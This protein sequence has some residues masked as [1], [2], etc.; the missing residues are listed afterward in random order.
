MPGAESDDFE[1]LEVFNPDPANTIGL[2][3]LT[4]GGGI[5]F[6]VPDGV[7]LKPGERAV[8]VEN[9]S[10]FRFRYGQLVPRP[11]V[12]GSYSGKLDNGGEGLTV[13]GSDGEQVVVVH[14]SDDPPWP[15]GADGDGRSLVF[16]GKAHS[17]IVGDVTGWRTSIAID[18]T[19]GYRD[20]LDFEDWAKSAGETLSADSDNDSDGWSSLLEYV[21][22]IDPVGDRGT[23]SV[24]RIWQDSDREQIHG[25]N[26]LHLRWGRPL[27]A[28]DVSLMVEVSSDFQSW[29]PVVDPAVTDI[30]GRIALGVSSI[31]VEG[32]G[33]A[34]FI[35]FK[36]D[37]EPLVAADVANPDP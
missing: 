23:D 10:A 11:R 34:R 35:R 16:A 33:T 8:V 37:Q 36:A 20:W 27:L 29:S 30:S 26:S 14:Y 17:G 3:G 9:E 2:S 24:P 32:D 1:F 13:T 7:T 12:L 28:E 15:T 6:Q 25:D 19:P 18:G 22:A 4:L 31:S 5:H 21:L